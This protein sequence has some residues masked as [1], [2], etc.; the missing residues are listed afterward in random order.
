MVFFAKISHLAVGPLS[1][2]FFS[3]KIFDSVGI[4][5]QDNGGSRS[6][7]IWSLNRGEAVMVYGNYYSRVCTVPNQFQF[8]IY[9]CV[10]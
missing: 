8:I 6:Q 5:V 4:G 10:V 9:K 7:I 3:M 2:F 1:K